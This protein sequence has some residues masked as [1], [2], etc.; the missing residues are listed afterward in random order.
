MFTKIEYTVH[1]FFN[2]HIKVKYQVNIVGQ[3]LYSD[4]RFLLVK[5]LIYLLWKQYSVIIVRMRTQH[6][7][8]AGRIYIIV[9]DKAI[10]ALD[11]RKYEQRG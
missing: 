7:S 10:I 4:E 6:Q 9:M 3:Y 5:A 1:R 8:L 2:V 11:T